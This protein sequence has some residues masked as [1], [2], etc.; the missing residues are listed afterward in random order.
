MI[1]N[2]RFKILAES[3]NYVL[4][5][6]YEYGY[7][8]NKHTGKEFYL[9]DSYGD[10]TFGLIDKNEN[11]ALLFGHDSY[12]WT[13]A[14]ITHLNEELYIWEHL[15]TW[16]YDAR[17]VSDFEVEILHEPDTDNAAIFSFNIK[18]MEVKK[19][20]DFKKIEILYSSFEK[21]IISW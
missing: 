16:P 12:L 11:W 4:G 9:G 20:A 15:F 18:T 14:D 19:T 21:P 13:P 3:Q 2:D 10:P 7:L 5:N 1:L 8:I 17:Q 6:E